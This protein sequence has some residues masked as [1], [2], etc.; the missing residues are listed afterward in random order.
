VSIPVAVRKRGF[1]AGRLLG[2]RIR[3]PPGAR[4]FVSR[5]CSVMQVEDSATG[6]SPTQ[7]SATEHVCMCVIDFDQVQ[8]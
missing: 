6:Q 5:E 7:G 4:I 1:E 8:Q 2:L 3:N